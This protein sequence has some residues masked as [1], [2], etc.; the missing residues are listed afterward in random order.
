MESDLAK[1]LP[2]LP[3]AAQTIIDA[4]LT[5]DQRVLLFGPPGVGK[6]TLAAQLADA[7]WRAGRSCQC[8]SADPGLPAFGVPGAI[9][10]GTRCKS[11]WDVIDLEPLCTLDAGRFRLPLVLAFQRLLRK[12]SAGLLLIDSPGV[13]RGVVGKEILQG[14][15]DAAQADSVLALAAQD[16]VPRLFGELAALCPQMFFVPAAAQARRPGKRARA[17]LRTELWDT[18]LADAEEQAIEL[19]AINVIGTPPPDEEFETWRGRQVALLRDGQLVTMGEIVRK[20][21]AR[22]VLRAPAIASVADTLLI[23]DAARHSEGLLESTAGFAGDRAHYLPAADSL[24][25]AIAYGGPRLV[26]RVGVA[27][28]ALVNGLFGDPLLHV[29]LRH[30]RRS[31]LFDLGDCGRLPARLAHQVSD[32]FISHAHTDHLGG[33]L[34]L[35]RSRIGDFPPCRLYGPPGLAEHIRGLVAGFLWDRVGDRGPIF[36]INELSEATVNR[37]RVQAGY[38]GCVEMDTRLVDEGV[39]LSEPGFCVRAVTLDHHTP[40]LAYAFE[41][42]RILNIRK[43]RLRARGWQPGPWLTE[44]KQRLRKGETDALVE[45]PDGS[46]TN[47]AELCEQLI[48]VTPGKRLVYATDLADSPSNRERLIGLARNAHTLFLEASF[49]EADV[50]HAIDNGHLTSRACGEIAHAALVNRLV[51]FHLS[52]RYTDDPQPLFDELEAVCDRVVLPDLPSRA[53]TSTTDLTLRNPPNKPAR[54]M[55]D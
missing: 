4:V 5:S 52:R 40:V 47:V 38:S 9:A 33:F 53:S 12:T 7:L 6:S 14:L 2:V 26:G 1:R 45:L 3:N 46:V 19:T 31:L 32:V 8:I 36:V 15:L 16:Q 44:L 43:D 54:I 21:S 17:R 13:V 39:I 28:V 49:T 41:P 27:D 18:Y 11:G 24:P 30:A 37:Y 34:W 23:R 29:R 48:M 35:L 55:E 22:L 20:Q 50:A 51:P 25:A 10:L 42:E